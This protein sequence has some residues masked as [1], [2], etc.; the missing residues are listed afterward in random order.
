MAITDGTASLTSTYIAKRVD[1]LR[2]FT[3]RTGSAAEAEDIVQEIYVK[4]A[5]L[6]AA[7][8]G[9]P[10]A[11]LYKMGSNILLDRLRSRRR[12]AV[13]DNAYF[14]A[15]A[16]DAGS[17][18]P[19]APSVSPEAAWAARRRLEEVMRVVAEFPPQRRRVFSMHKIDGLSYGEVAEK[20]GISKSAVE[21]HMIAALRQLLEAEAE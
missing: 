20:L 19:V 9:N 21:K 2:F 12:T 6:D 8:I 1:L 7:S 11:F 16:A 17:M 18:E 13:R 14:D 15:H 4:I 3:L 10:A 5:R